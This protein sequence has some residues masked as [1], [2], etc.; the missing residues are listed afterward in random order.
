MAGFGVNSF[1]YDFFFTRKIDTVA[2]TCEPP[3][4]RAGVNTLAVSMNITYKIKK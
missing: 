2:N 3:S 4:E 1:R